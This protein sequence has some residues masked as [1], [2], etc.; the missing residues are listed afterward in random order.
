M[1]RTK[2]LKILNP[3]L[4]VVVL[5]QAITALLH[6][7]IPD[8]VFEVVHSTGGVL[9]LLGIALHVTLNW[10]WIRANFGKPKAPSA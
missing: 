8:K 7:T 1:N 5:C 4:G 9:L 3:T 6:E 2:A 10:N